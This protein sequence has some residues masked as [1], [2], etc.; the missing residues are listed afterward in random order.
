M[1]APR[2]LLANLSSISSAKLKDSY[3]RNIA[4]SITCTHLPNVVYV[5]SGEKCIIS[6]FKHTY[7]WITGEQKKIK[8]CW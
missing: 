6:I 2:R 4:C 1:L 8:Q 3:S 5:S 7:L